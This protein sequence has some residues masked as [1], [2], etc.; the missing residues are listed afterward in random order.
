MKTCVSCGAQNKDWDNTGTMRDGEY[1]CFQCNKKF[2]IPNC[3]MCGECKDELT[4]DYNEDTAGWSYIE[5]AY[6]CSN[7]TDIYWITKRISN[8]EMLKYIISE[9]IQG[10]LKDIE[11]KNPGMA[12]S[13][14]LDM[15]RFKIL[16]DNRVIEFDVDELRKS[17]KIDL[18]ETIQATKVKKIV[19]SIIA[20][21][22]D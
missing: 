8:R 5:D 10:C 11:E 6:H 3:V 12:L 1:Y 15:G 19:R 7:C 14:I 17:K 2:E 4:A 18:K 9:S 22:F 20:E 16:I 21:T 13:Y